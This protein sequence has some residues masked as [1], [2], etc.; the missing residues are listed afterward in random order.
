MSVDQT[1]EP[2]EAPPR[3][4]YAEHH[5]PGVQSGMQSALLYNVER[6]ALPT[7]LDPR[8]PLLQR[9]VEDRPPLR[10][11]GQFPGGRRQLRLYRDARLGL[12]APAGL[13]RV[14]LL[15]RVQR[16]VH[17]DRGGHCDGA[18]PCPASGSPSSSPSPSA[19]LV[20]LG[21]GNTVARLGVNSLIVTL[22]TSGVLLGVVE[23]YT[24]SQSINNGHL[25]SLVN[26]GSANFLGIPDVVYLLFGVAVVVYYVLQH[27]PYGRYLTSIGSNARAARLVGLRVARFKLSAFVVAGGI[28]RAWPAC[29][30]W[31]R[32]AAP[33]PR[34]G[35]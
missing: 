29:S 5:Q 3:S 9:V 11:V 19:P 18:V 34:R 8:P 10:L 13:R 26:F 1:D 2:D 4:G 22:G 31:P 12:A 30:W 20:G 24:G 16:R 32:T 33:P 7:I 21:N 15:G 25:H 14:R 6:F 27:T 23:W 28:G 17:P 35:P